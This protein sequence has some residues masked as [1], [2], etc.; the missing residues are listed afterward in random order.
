MPAGF[1]AMH[2]LQSPF[3]GEQDALHAALPQHKRICTNP[4]LRRCSMKSCGPF[5]NSAETISPRPKERP[6]YGRLSLPI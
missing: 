5:N 3:S 4:K 1:F 2:Y 6:R